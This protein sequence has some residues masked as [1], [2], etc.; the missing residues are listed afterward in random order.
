MNFADIRVKNL[1]EKLN[2]TIDMH[3]GSFSKY[4]EGIGNSTAAGISNKSFIKLE[5]IFFFILFVPYRQKQS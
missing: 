5:V 4:F 2:Y 3:Q 1:K